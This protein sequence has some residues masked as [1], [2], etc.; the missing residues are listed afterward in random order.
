MERIKASK[1]KFYII[2][3]IVFI[4]LY[5]IMF[6]EELSINDIKIISL[7]IVITLVIVIIVRLTSNY[8][9]DG[10]YFS[11]KGI[12]YIFE[13]KRYFANWENLNITKK[14]EFKYVMKLDLHIPNEHNL[15][16]ALL[17]FWPTEDDILEKTKKHCPKNHELY[18]VIERYAKNRSLPF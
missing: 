8:K 18:I 7:S 1:I 5:L 15:K 3:S 17:L 11:E 14:I 9:S 2:S 12:T 10:A 16:F 13:N 6:L 4:I